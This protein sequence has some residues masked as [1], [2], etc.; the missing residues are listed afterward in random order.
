MTTTNQ[1]KS[2]NTED[3]TKVITNIFR[4]GKEK[5]SRVGGTKALFE[6]QMRFKCSTAF[7][8]L[9]QRNSCSK[10]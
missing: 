5:T 8:L 9:R 2:D 6:Q 10:V 1:I 7:R 4:N 3:Y